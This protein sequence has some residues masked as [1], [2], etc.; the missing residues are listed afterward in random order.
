MA[1]RTIEI[2]ERLVSFDTTSR[3]S[4]LELI[5]YVESLLMEHGVQSRRIPDGRDRVNLFASI[6]DT[7]APGL[8]MGGHTDVVPVTGQAWRSEPFELTRM[9]DRLCGRGSA[10]MKG[11]L[12]AL[13]AALP[14][15]TASPLR[16]PITLAFTYDEEIGCVGIR[17]LLDVMVTMPVKP[18]WAIIGEPTG[19]Q[20]VT[21]HKG[22]VA[23]RVTVTGKEGHSSN[24]DAGVNAIDVACDAMDFIRERGR[25]CKHAGVSDHD[26][27]YPWS[28]FHVGRISGGTAVNILPGVCCFDFEIRNLPE[29]DGD[30]LL[31]TVRGF[32]RDELRQRIKRMDERCDV[33]LDVV[34][35]YPGLGTDTGSELVAFAAEMA[36]NPETAKVDFGTE[37]GMIQNRLGTDCVVCGPGH[38]A[39][40]HQPDEFVE[41][42][43]LNRCDQFLRNVVGALRR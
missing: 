29:E 3:S 17:D 15:M 42:E 36:G 10:D 6:G 7:T 1:S 18:R 28:S 20:V 37:A 43:Q 38:I 39:Q 22:K 27:A 12:A 19:M 4:N 11:F 32:I 13:L 40:A 31:E 30:A 5:Q 14:E 2:L 33:Q 34:S 23:C 26:Y 25:A 35:S 8:F 16:M 21:A 24:P 41:V 9:D